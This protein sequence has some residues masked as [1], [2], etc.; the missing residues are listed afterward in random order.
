MQAITVVP[1]ERIANDVGVKLEDIGGAAMLPRRL[2]LDA[3]TPF[4]T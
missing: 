1:N 4:R 2:W 3:R